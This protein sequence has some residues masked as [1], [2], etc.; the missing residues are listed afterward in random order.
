MLELT[1]LVDVVMQST[2]EKGNLVA[3][4]TGKPEA[5]AGCKTGGR[6]A[7]WTGDSLHPK[8]TQTAGKYHQHTLFPFFF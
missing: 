6:R 5:G 2:A 8:T 4:S 3:K 7:I 1:L